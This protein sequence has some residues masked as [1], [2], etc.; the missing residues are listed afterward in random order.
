MKKALIIAALLASAISCQALRYE[1]SDSVKV[2]KLL[3]EARKSGIS[4]QEQCVKFF[5][6]KFYG[7][8]Y[9]AHTLEVKGK[10]D[11]VVNLRELDCTTYV[12]NVT[13]LTLC[14]K[15]RQYT[16]RAFCDKL[17]RIRYRKGDKLEY[18]ARLHYYSE[19]IDD[20]T[21]AG[22]CREIQSPRPPFTGLQKVAVDFMSTHPDKY[23]MLKGDKTAI[24]SIAEMERRISGRTYRYIPKNRI[25]NSRLLRQTVHDGDIIVIIT[26]I[27]G[28]DTQHLGFASWHKDG[29]HLVNASSIHHKV[30]EEPMLLRTYLQ[31]HKTMTGIRIVRLNG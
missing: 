24:R 31:R 16:F 7:T 30:V 10:E 23:S 21:R 2:E 19:W 17:R 5:T 14:M 25:D 22:I 12:E 13:A 11:L 18:A 28:L 1:A 27:K 20:N 3:N 6:R 8:P 4:G 15:D 26:N 29:L 9:V